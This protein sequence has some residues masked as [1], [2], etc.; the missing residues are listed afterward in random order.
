[1]EPH[2]PFLRAKQSLT[3]ILDLMFGRDELRDRLVPLAGGGVLR[4]SAHVAMNAQP[5]RF[6]YKEL[7]KMHPTTGRY[8]SLWGLSPFIPA[9]RRPPNRRQKRLETRLTL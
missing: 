9:T 3:Q 5:S 8:A 2:Q 4:Q 6:A 7:W 1:A